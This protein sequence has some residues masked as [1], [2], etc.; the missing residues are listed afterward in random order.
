MTAFA[1]RSDPSR[2]TIPGAPPRAALLDW[3]PGQQLATIQC[4][5]DFFARWRPT[6]AA[7][8]LLV[9]GA[10]VYCV[11]KTNPRAETPDAWTR[12]LTIASPTEAPKRWDADAVNRAL[13]FLTGDRWHV[14][15]YR[16]PRDPLA[17]LRAAGKPSRPA[18]DAVSLFS[19]GLDSLC[20]VIDLLESDPALRL[21]LVAHNEGAKASPTQRTLHGELA[22]HYGA[23]RVVLR[24]LYL[25]PAPPHPSQRVPARKAIETT[26]RGR[27]FLFLSA[28]LALASAAGDA[29]P[30][31]VPENG[32][33]ALNVPLTRARAGSFSTRTTHPHFLELFT[34]FAR[35]VGV[36]NPIVNPYRWRTKGEM[37]A[38]SANPILL[39]D[40]A[41]ITI[42]CSH[43]EA[44]RYQQR[45][46]GNCGYCY[47]CMIRRAALASV[48]WDDHT[49]AWNVLNDPTLLAPTSRR[50]ADLRAL[51]NG[52]MADRP[53][54]D[55]L[56]AAPLPGDRAEHV[57]T[58][59]RGNA[60]LRKWITSGARRRLRSLV[61]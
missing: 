59:R 14:A 24:Q 1:T 20:G 6:R 12:D 35:S 28:A 42:S 4:R 9:L 57:A 36:A 52:I 16:E 44:A 40:L 47:P 3:A 38:G 61:T 17:G 23:D 50:G 48:G 22:R 58:W 5:A 32:Y 39:R 46:Q 15:P 45:P 7:A 31:Y 13:S 53:D 54:I 41:P 43:P 27:S 33:I 25:R 2:T 11:D 18:I 55:V 8:D 21:G 26:T 29:V 10:G 60:E 19:G 51:V 49:Y 37:C 56:R 34:A 30:V